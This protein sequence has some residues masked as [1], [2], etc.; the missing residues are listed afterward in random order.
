MLNIYQ[1]LKDDVSINIPDL[2][3]DSKDPRC[4]DILCGFL[5]LTSFFSSQR[6][7]KLFE[8]VLIHNLVVIC[9][10]Y[11]KQYV[12]ALTVEWKN[13]DRKTTVPAT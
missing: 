1:K 4:L 12:E 10:D 7:I 2:I 11:Y 13:L 6:M 8:I 3:Y 9:L 5:S